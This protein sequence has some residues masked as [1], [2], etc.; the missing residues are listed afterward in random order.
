MNLSIVTTVCIQPRALPLQL[1]GEWLGSG[2]H[3]VQ[4]R[5]F[6][7]LPTTSVNKP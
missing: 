7:C 1:K 6:Y 2:K 3:V 4:L 5:G